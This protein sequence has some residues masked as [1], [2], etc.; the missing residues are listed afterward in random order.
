[1]F[2]LFNPNTNNNIGLNTNNN[3]ISNNASNMS[4]TSQQQQQQTASSLNT[5]NRRQQ[6]LNRLQQSQLSRS[7]ST[8]NNNNN[9]AITNTNTVG[10]TLNPAGENSSGS[11]DSQAVE[12]NSD[13]ATFREALIMH[14]KYFIF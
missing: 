6:S 4:I 8:T 10:S 3:L 14:S 13:L 9:N 7:N 12:T 1:M 5:N 2:N 11:N